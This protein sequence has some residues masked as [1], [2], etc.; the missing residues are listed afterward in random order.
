MIK[1]QEIKA[2][3]SDSIVFFR[4]GDFYEMFFEDA[5]IASSVLGLTL[6]GRDCGLEQRAPMC[7][8]PHH[9]SGN[10]IRKLV[11]AGHRVAVCEQLTAPT[12]GKGMVERGV[13][14]VITAGTY[15]DEGYLDSGKNNYVAST[16]TSGDKA[17]ISWCDITTGEFYGMNT[18]TANVK[19][20]IAMISPREQIDSNGHY[21]YA[22][23][24][25]SAYAAII[26][27]FNIT[28]T[29]IFDLEKDDAVIN[30]AGALLHYLG[31][32][33]KTTLSNIIKISVVKSSEHMMIDKI[34]R[35]NLE[36]SNKKNSLLW[37]LDDTLTPMGKREIARQI[38]NPLLSIE[39]INARLNAVEDLAVD[40]M[41][42][43][44]LREQLKHV[45]DILR[46]CGKAVSGSILPRD[47]LAIKSSIESLGVIKETLSTFKGL[48][49]ECNNGVKLLP[50]V[51][52]LISKALDD[53]GVIRDGYDK[54]LDECRNAEKYGKEWLSRLEATEREETKIK[55]LKVSYNRV[56]GYYFEVPTKV[57]AN[58][59]YRFTRKGS[60][61]T[62][63]RYI[64][65]ELKKIEDKILNSNEAALSIEQRIY[66]DLRKVIIENIN[67][68]T[69]NAKNIAMIDL[70]QSFA[71]AS[72]RNGYKR[73]NINTGGVIKL[74]N[75]RH[76]VV[77]KLIGNA[78]FIANDCELKNTTMLITGPNMAG[79]STFMRMIANIVIMAHLG[80]FVPCDVADIAIT[81]RIFTRI[82]AS[83]SLATGESTFM[84]EMNEVSN[85]VHNATSKSLILL[86]EVGRGTGTSDG[87][88]LASSIATYITDK[89]GANAMFATHF[90]ELTNLA[91]SNKRIQN[92]KVLTEQIGNEIVFLHKLEQ[93]IEQNSFGIDVA[94]LAGLPREIIDEARKLYSKIY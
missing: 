82:G 59:P 92:Y 51:C 94:R 10:Y 17:S 79:K 31:M 46:F 11:D 47:F 72:F 60:T 5:K 16:Y 93:G 69:E 63:E 22:F 8:I 86:D 39:K 80:C 83:D 21:G 1:W 35:E 37:V 50:D 53:D 25:A 87:L 15:D 84:V 49:S 74:E 29:K 44:G 20:V 19:D 81:D 6:T 33:Q 61:A 9:A 32:T 71:F 4:L 26:R 77:E 52:N 89:I 76:P 34:A 68:L 75:A 56:S 36:I 18:T 65:D 58:V 41:A 48:I 27:Q 78:N 28:S 73:P 54:G 45:G 14:R 64:T 85:I 13:V 12:K 38:G 23:S 43:R 90:H 62:T 66:T 67:V 91:N 24:G 40:V 88:A 55:E 57:S 30:S 42:L 2:E 7:G 70:L 3:H